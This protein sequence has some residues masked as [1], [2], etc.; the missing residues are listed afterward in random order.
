MFRRGWR[1]SARNT[2]LALMAAAGVLLASA[3]V[4]HAADES[5]SVDAPAGAATA[6]VELEQAGLAADDVVVSV[7]SGSG[8]WRSV[9]LA[10]TTLG[11][12]GEVAVEPGA[13]QVLV[14]AAVGAAASSPDAAV[15]IFDA[16]SSPIAATNVRL[17][18]PAAGGGGG[19]GGGG[20]TAVVVPPADG[21]ATAPR[22]GA[23]A[24]TGGQSLLLAALVVGAVLAVGA[25]LAVRAA[26]RRARTGTEA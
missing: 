20:G 8:P 26:R 19:G 25:A 4:A 18:V 9:A 3:G 12:H 6:W 24:L 7:R 21:A 5:F 10:P 13:V 17:A 11:L 1:A 16:A 15:T 2:A 22:A 14:R 23:L